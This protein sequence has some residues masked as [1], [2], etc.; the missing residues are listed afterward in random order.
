M[1]TKQTR[2]V[3]RVTGDDTEIKYDDV[4]LPVEEEKTEPLFP[5]RHIELTKP[6][7]M[8]KAE[9]QDV[10]EALVLHLSHT[11]IPKKDTMGGCFTVTVPKRSRAYFVEFQLNRDYIGFRVHDKF[12]LQ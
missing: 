7:A 2:R 6:A 4:E 5:I 10:F 1:D 3:I 8:P 9:L 11:D 12:R